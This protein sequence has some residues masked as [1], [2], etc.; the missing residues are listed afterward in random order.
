MA[1]ATIHPFLLSLVRGELADGLGPPPREPAA[2]DAILAEAA[3]QQI[4]PLLYRWLNATGGRGQLPLSQQDWLRAEVFRIA[5][6]N[7]ILAEELRAILLQFDIRQVAC[8]PIRGLA[9]AELLY[10]EDLPR[11]TGDLDLLVKKGDL[12]AVTDSLTSLGFQL[13]ERRAGFAESYDYALVFAKQRHGLIVVEPHWSLAYPPF[14]DSVDMEGVWQRAVVGQVLGVPA[15]LLHV[16]DL[17]LH[18]CL[19]L[20][21]WR[22]RAPLLWYYELDQLIRRSNPRLAWR[23]VLSRAQESGQ[24]SLVREVAHTLRDLCGTPGPDQGLPELDTHPVP[25][26]PGSRA[27]A[28]RRRAVALLARRAGG[29]GRE[30]FAL[31]LSLKG[32]RGKLRYALSLLFPSP[33]YMRFRYGPGGRVTLAWHYVARVWNLSCQAAHWLKDL[34]FGLNTRR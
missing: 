14:T 23:E 24:S 22:E 2:W 5:A 4:L 16:H 32:I 30:E 25:Q 9:L 1:A 13:I 15:Q 19:H 17:V 34:A 11:P 29:S 12:P 10:G 6:H 20:I 31:L 3:E 26:R 7:A 27:G 28:L 33:E 18:L 21:H 8:A